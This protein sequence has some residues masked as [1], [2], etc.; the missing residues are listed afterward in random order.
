MKK[1]GLLLLFIFLCQIAEARPPWGSGFNESD[2]NLG[3]N[4][5]VLHE[6]DSDPV[7]PL[8]DEIALYAK[9]DGGTTKFYTKDAAANVEAL[10]GSSAISDAVYGVGWNG[11]TTHSPSKNSVYDKI[12]ALSLGSGDVTSVGDC[13]DGACYD[14]SS[15]GGTY[16]R[17][18][19]GDSHYTAIVS[20]NVSADTTITLPATTGTLLLTNGAGTALTA[21]NG[22]NIQ[23]DTIDD[24][25][26]D[27]GTGV[28]QISASDMPDED[29]GDI[30]IATG[31][32]T[33]DANAVALATDTTGNYVATI[34][35]SGASE[36]TV[37]NS[38][39]ENAAVTLAVASTITRDEEWNTEAEVQTAWGSVNILLETEI[40]ASSEL[41]AL[42]DDETGS[43]LLV[44]G[45]SP[46]FLG[47][48]VIE[49]GLDIGTAQT[50]TD[51]D[52]TPAVT[53]GAYFNTNTS[54]VTI[55]DFDGTI[56]DGQVIW[57]VSKGDI[58]YDCTAAGFVC[59]S[60][61]LV[62]ASGDLT[63]WVYD[64]T[65]W[66]LGQV[67]DAS[68]PSGGGITALT[69]DAGGS[70]TG[71]TVTLAG[72]T[73]GIDTSRSSDTVTFNLDTT[74]IES[75][76]L[77][78]GAAATIAL[79]GDVSGT[80]T[81]F[82]FDNGFSSV[83]AD[84]KI[85]GDDLFMATN[86][87][88]AA[89]IADGTNFNPVVI[90]GD[91]AIGTTGTA[92]IQANSVALTTDTTGNYVESVAT[93]TLT[94]LTGGAAGS[95]GAVLSLAFDYT[96]TLAGNP[97]IAA[98]LWIPGTT[99]II[100]EGATADTIEGLLTAADV[101]SSDKTWT[102]PDRSG[103]VILSG[104]TFSGDVTGTLEADGD[105]PLTIADSV[106]VTGWVLGTSSATTLTSGT[107]NIDLLD[108]VG[109]V[110]MDYGSA[111]VT[112]HTFTTDGT[113]TA[114]IVL[115]AGSIDS[116]EILDGTITLADTA[117]TAGR[118]LT[119]ATNDI[120][121]DAELYTDTKCIWFEN[122]TAA[123]D[124]KSIWFAKNA[125]TIT[126][127]WAESDQT[128][129]FMLQVD[130]GTPADVDTVDLAPAAGTAEDTSLDGDA[131]MAAG[132]RLDLAVTSVASTPTWCS[133]CWTGTWDD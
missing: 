78:A 90:S 87:S 82:T 34:A 102:L 65:D 20:S 83:S 66:I 60:T 113:G 57:V 25:S 52:A 126:S 48:A 108:A 68:A 89:L 74:E 105:T 61:D 104:D 132:D 12:E 21:L 13:A 123:D 54:A 86:T 91:V 51:L 62:T 122:P 85:L 63:S 53:D 99:G 95:E 9:D 125:F 81:N 5:L 70:T 44:F 56:V 119:I 26:L 84:F 31:A 16:A 98:N 69:A 93:A 118:S 43:G 22:E 41:L 111:D 15:D 37:A 103:T 79:T 129:T 64:G 28:D 1:T 4:S 6:K 32:Y 106:T 36:V 112:D 40:D 7:T 114:E 133:I 67:L 35:D 3:K 30:S 17:L 121:A 29:L 39:T 107:V 42:M 38:G 46:T 75:S 71:T 117:I 45:T 92:T 27:F 76:T 24:D 130:D 8:T 49:G 96:S 109:A 120:A 18:Y 116:T 77:G 124:F 128:V 73:N 97:G 80:D 11:D 59:G 19:D 50:F 110:D 10:I 72:G 2:L 14:G 33:I 94:G 88:G 115:P 101:T 58:T 131:T 127:I 47:T 100:F 23:D 55:T